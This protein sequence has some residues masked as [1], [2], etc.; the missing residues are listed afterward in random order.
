LESTSAVLNPG[1]L[2][3]P[4]REIEISDREQVQQGTLRARRELAVPGTVFVEPG[5][6]V[7][8][9]TLV[10]RSSRQFLR[11]FFLDVRFSLKVGPDEVPRYMLKKVGDE[12]VSGEVIARRKGH[13]FSTGEFRSNVSGRIERILPS[14]TVVVREKPEESFEL[15]AVSVA[16]DLRMRPHQIKRH[17]RVEVGQKVDRGQAIAA[18]MRPGD[19]RMSKS[20]VRGKVKE[21]NEQFGIVMI[22]PLL[23]E[24]EVRAWMPGRVVTVSDKGCEIA[25]EGIEIVGTWGRGG[26][27]HGALTFADPSPGRIL[28][29]E[30][31]TREDLVGLEENG[32]TGLVVGGLYLKD[33]RELTVSYTIVMTGE[34]GE[35]EIDPRIHGL[36]LKWEGRLALLDGRTELRVGVRRPRILLPEASS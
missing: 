17:L 5:E 15:E 24:L 20:P 19:I 1:D 32:V 34:F 4:S 7:R 35:K 9:D 36:L 12:I 30:F 23:E 6:T 8:P 10:G 13:V 28:V 3:P 29:K 14:G 18:M 16:K 26:E 27:V 2:E 31:A 21:I 33:A 11:P 25:N 22:E